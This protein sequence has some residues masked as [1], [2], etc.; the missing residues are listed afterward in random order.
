MKKYRIFWLA[1]LTM[2]FCLTAR[3]ESAP[4]DF[5][6]FGFG[7]NFPDSQDTVAVYGFRLGLPVCGGQAAVSGIEFAI[8]GAAGDRVNGIQAA[9]IMAVSKEVNGLQLSIYNQVERGGNVQVGI[10]NVAKE[11]GFQI[12]LINHIEGACLPWTILFNCKF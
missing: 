11:N 12:G 4:W 9:P 8:I 10:V 5:L 1:A 3:A 7:T 6:Q 2:A